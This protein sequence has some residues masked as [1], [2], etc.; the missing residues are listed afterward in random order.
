[1]EPLAARYL[2]TFWCDPNPGHVEQDRVVDDVAI[3]GLRPEKTEVIPI[4]LRSQ[5]REVD[6]EGTIV[7]YVP[8]ALPSCQSE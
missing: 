1:M 4:A 8:S 3:M 6:D 7:A 2:L 5:S